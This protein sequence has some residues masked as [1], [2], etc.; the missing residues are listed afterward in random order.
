MQDIDLSA[1]SPC[2]VGSVDT[3][4]GAEAV[5]VSSGYAYLADGES[6]VQIIDISNPAAPTI[7]RTV[8]TPDKALGISVAG[9]RF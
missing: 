2:L 5:Y 9:S 6:G 3:P 4:G 1:P 8:K 7:V